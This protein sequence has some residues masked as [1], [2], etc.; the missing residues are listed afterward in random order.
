MLK[1]PENFDMYH[2]KNINSYSMASYD[3]FSASLLSKKQ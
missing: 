3:R 1:I 2:V